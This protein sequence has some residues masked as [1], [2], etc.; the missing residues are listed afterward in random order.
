MAIKS[1]SR[2]G[3]YTSCK[4]LTVYASS[5]VHASGDWNGFLTD[6]KPDTTYHMEIDLGNMYRPSYCRYGYSN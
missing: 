4:L 2:Q 1:R 5:R 3:L 6:V